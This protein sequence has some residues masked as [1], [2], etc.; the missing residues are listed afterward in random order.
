LEVALSDQALGAQRQIGYQVRNLDGSND[1]NPSNDLGQFTMDLPVDLQAVGGA[2]TGSV[3][4]T[5]DLPVG[6]ENNGPRPPGQRQSED[7]NVRVKLDVP[8]GTEVVAIPTGCMDLN[9]DDPDDQ[10]LG[11]P[12]YQC[13]L[14]GQPPL[15]AGTTKLFTF[16]VK[17]TGTP[18]AL[19]MSF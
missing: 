18:A 17:V 6:V 19:G 16:K 1:A 4:D 7:F 8:T 12:S 9:L 3:G 10:Q 5:G 14:P 2:A 13:F 11:Q 15:T